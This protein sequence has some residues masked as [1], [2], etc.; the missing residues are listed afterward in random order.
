MMITLPQEVRSQYPEV[1]NFWCEYP[2]SWQMKN[3]FGPETFEYTP[4]IYKGKFT[5]CEHAVNRYTR[6]LYLLHEELKDTPHRL[7]KNYK[8][9]F[10]K[11]LS[12]AIL[13]GVMW[14]ITNDRPVCFGQIGKRPGYGTELLKINERFYTFKDYRV[15]VFKSPDD[16]FSTIYQWHVAR[17]TANIVFLTRENTPL[18]FKKSAKLFYFFS[19]HNDWAITENVVYSHVLKSKCC[20]YYWFNRY[21]YDKYSAANMMSELL[22]TDEP[23]KIN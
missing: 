20:C 2:E 22:N 4:I 3:P 17:Q 15:G 18:F 23:F 19:E 6:T 11:N 7:N 13:F 8:K 5:D 14:D 1:F 21:K 16:H 10:H 9:W 12:N